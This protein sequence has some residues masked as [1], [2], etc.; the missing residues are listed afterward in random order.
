M[1]TSLTF[2]F[3]AAPAPSRSAAPPRRPQDKRPEVVVGNGATVPFHYLPPGLLSRDPTTEVKNTPKVPFPQ[4]TRDQWQAVHMAVTSSPNA[5]PGSYELKCD[6]L[7]TKRLSRTQSFTMAKRQLGASLQPGPAPYSLS[8][9]TLKAFYPRMPEA[10]MATAGRPSDKPLPE[11]P[12]PV[13]YGIIKKHRPFIRFSTAPGHDVP[14]G[15]MTTAAIP[16]RDAH[17]VRKH[18]PMVRFSSAPR[19]GN[20]ASTF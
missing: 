12:G 4:S 8:E 17:R 14:P 15:D 11:S 9:R 18:K 19:F 6:P 2:F 16:I 5:G 7:S 1:R 10:V 20:S 13:E 3:R